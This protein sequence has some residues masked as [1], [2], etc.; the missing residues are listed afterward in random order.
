M[1][2]SWA[3]VGGLT[4]ALGTGAYYHGK[5]TAIRD[6]NAYQRQTQAPLKDLKPTDP[7]SIKPDH[8]PTNTEGKERDSTWSSTGDI[9]FAFGDQGRY[10]FA[11]RTENSWFL[12]GVTKTYGILNTGIN[13]RIT[14]P[15]FWAWTSTD[16]ELL[17]YMD[18]ITGKPT[19]QFRMDPDRPNTAPTYTSLQHWLTENVNTEEEMLKTKVVF[20]AKSTYFAH[21]GKKCIYHDLPSPLHKFLLEKK[22]ALSDPE[23]DPNAWIPRIVALGP[24][25][26]FIA[27]WHDG[28]KIMALSSHNSIALLR[29]EL[30]ATSDTKFP[31]KKYENIVL[32]PFSSANYF[33]V[34]KTGHISWSMAASDETHLDL[35]THLGV[36]SQVRA[37]EDGT[38]FNVSHTAGN[39]VTRDLDITPETNHSAEDIRRALEKPPGLFSGQGRL[40]I[41]DRVRA[42]L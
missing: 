36:Y 19:W 40:G 38:E 39:G 10:F 18:A 24:E 28:S 4:A 14:R 29:T 9:V 16:D 15:Y 27:I 1:N 12:K 6:F 31:G 2:L 35:T 3:L 30:M 33:R 23:G 21:N 11:Y 17:G 42:L 37:R 13:E 8:P 5:T 20:G 41:L 25:N 26:T 7:P 34:K 22:Y 32:S